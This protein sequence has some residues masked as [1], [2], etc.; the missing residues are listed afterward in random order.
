MKRF[1]NILAAVTLGL[2]FLSPGFIIGQEL[3][4]KADKLFF[5]YAYPQ[6]ITEYL[7]ER[8]EKPLTNQQMLN[9]A[10]AYLQTG[11]YESASDTYLEVFKA[12]SAMNAYYLNKMLL[13]MARTE[14]PDRI[15]AYLATRQTSFTP[16]LLE[17]AE[18]NYELLGK[19][20]DNSLQFEIFNIREN[21]PQ[22]DFSPMF[23]K[24]R[25]LF[26]SARG[27]GKKPVYGPSGESY[28]DIFIASVG[29]DGDLQGS[30]PF[31][32]IPAS[33]FH[34]ATPYYSEELN[35]L[36][37]IRS[38]MEDGEML[39]TDAGKNALSLGMIDDLGT[40]KYALRDLSTSF[41]Y[42]FYS[43]KTSKLYFAA[44]LEGGYGGTDIYYVF[45]NNGLIM[46]S[47]INM[48]PRINTPGN[49]IAPYIFEN[50]FYFS[51]DVFYG[52]GGMDIYKSEMQE[53]DFL[54][55]PINLGKGINSEYDD[56]GF[57]IRNYGEEGLIGYFSSNRPG[58][59]GNDDIYGF[60]VAEKPGLKTFVLKGEVNNPVSGE[61]V[62]K[63]QIRLLDV[64][65]ELLKEIYA[66]E[67][68][69]YRVEIPWQSGIRIEATK[70]KY[71][72]YNQSFDESEMETLQNA[73]FRMEISFIEDLVEEK[74]GQ[75]VLKLNKAYFKKGST[76]ISPEVAAELN[77]VVDI[78]NKFPE[79]QL[80]IEVHT[81]SRGGSAT[82]FR[83][84]Q[85]RADAIKDYLQGNGV[86][87]SNILYAL[88]Y[89]EDKILNNCT[90]GV[91]CL[92]VL[93]KQN[94]RQL[95]VVLN[96]NILY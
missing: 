71:S 15:K 67:D 35:A 30:A 7:E 55:I 17:N 65:G 89:G 4:S 14:N 56:F 21:S 49:E 52:L 12:D 6:A 50:S 66:N 23:Y 31:K 29:T 43:A 77:K 78:V 91:Y 76:Q 84:S 61:G 27:H 24:D 85:G 93:H 59:A 39:F 75:T 3:T 96:Y 32:D 72:T 45:T 34:Q 22:A 10:D 54:S 5:E 40:F 74:E 37:Y 44:D 51:S 36:F 48:G 94:E 53:D 60:K 18:F 47:P 13:S 79:L 83:L 81:D 41:Y 69:D 2:V 28:M 68:G 33:P 62:S 11:K 19:E 25:L 70:E 87:A 20:A 26:T 88:G 46:S 42:P 57:I 63:A 16:E 92:E 80:R 95:I 8:S 1:T 73:P 86:P 58:G 82:N 90:N 9:L 38:N 64:N